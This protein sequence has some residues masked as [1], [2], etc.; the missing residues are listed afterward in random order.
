MTK[1]EAI[2]FFGTL[3]ALGKAVGVSKAAASLWAR[4]RLPLQLQQRIFAAAKMT[5]RKVPEHWQAE[6]D[7]LIAQKTLQKHANRRGA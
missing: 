7:L 1:E 4:E 6:I 5:G 3:T 2:D